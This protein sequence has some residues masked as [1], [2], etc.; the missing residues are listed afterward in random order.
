MN[1]LIN[2]SLGFVFSFLGF[3]FQ[4]YSKSHSFIQTKHVTDAGR[5]RLIKLVL[6]RD[7]LEGM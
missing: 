7:K 2:I 1:L 3:F 5:M 6:V 4:I